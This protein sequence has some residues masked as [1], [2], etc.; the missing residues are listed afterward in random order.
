MSLKAR[1]TAA[2]WSIA[3]LH[4]PGVDLYDPSLIKVDIFSS[5]L[6]YFSGVILFFKKIF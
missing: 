3:H 1:R 2:Q 5:S 4:Q 6:A